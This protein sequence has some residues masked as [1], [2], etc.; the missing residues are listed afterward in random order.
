MSLKTDYGLAAALNTAFDAGIAL[1][2]ST[3]TAQY[4]TMSTELAAAAALGKEEFTIQIECPTAQ[5]S[6]ILLQGKYWDAYKAGLE[7]GLATED[8]Y[9]YEY[10]IT[11][12]T[13]DA[14]TTY[15]DF[16]FSF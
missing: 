1:I 9:S 11:L 8:I 3:P 16:N 6:A 7:S 4:T 13:D 10:T 2:V 12:N 15:L 5:R 14:S